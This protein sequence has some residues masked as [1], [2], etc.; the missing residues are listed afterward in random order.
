MSLIASLSVAGSVNDGS[1]VI[2]ASSFLSDTFTACT[3]GW[4]ETPCSMVLT[5][6]WHVI[7][8]TNIFTSLLFLRQ[9]SRLSASLLSAIL[10][11]DRASSFCVKTSTIRLSDVSKPISPMAFSTTFPVVCFGEKVIFPSFS[12][13]DT[14]IFFTPLSVEIFPSMFFTQELQCIPSIPMY[15]TLR[16]SS[17][18]F[19]MSS[20]SSGKEMAPPLPFMATC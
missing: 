12:S 5:Q 15:T 9:T 14:S 6:D 18:S 7:P 17:L 1:Y 8:F 16:S 2:A 20:P 10:S 13:S 4:L 11:S 3:P 19:E